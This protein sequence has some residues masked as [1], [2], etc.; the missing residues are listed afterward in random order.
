M[1]T[2]SKPLTALDIITD[3]I[4]GAEVFQDCFTF[5]GIRPDGRYHVLTYYP[6]DI[7]EGRTELHA[8]AEDLRNA[9][10]SGGPWGDLA[11]KGA[12]VC[13][14]WTPV[15]APEFDCTAA[16]TFKWDAVAASLD[17]QEAVKDDQDP[18]QLL[19][20]L[21]LG[22]ILTIIPSGQCRAPWSSAR[23]CPLCNGSGNFPNV[24]Y[25][26]HTESINEKLRGEITRRNKDLLFADWPEADRIAAARIDVDLRH[27]GQNATCP[28][29]GGDGSRIRVEDQAFMEYLER[30]ASEIGAFITGSDGDGCDVLIQKVVQK[31]EPAEE[32]SEDSDSG[33]RDADE[34]NP[35]PGDPR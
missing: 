11:F 2:L 22:S 23:V 26:A 14:A 12:E 31:P 15:G 17:A 7:P 33:D 1:P 19:K 5:V 9:M 10:F 34:R 21:Y 30:K 28:F 13:T 25:D 20:S 35:E 29:C 24:L 18:D 16:D 32:P 6:D 4:P 27:G 3:R 8:M